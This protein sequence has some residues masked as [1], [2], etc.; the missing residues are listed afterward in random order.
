MSKKYTL[1]K[2]NS[3]KV[4]G[5]TL[6]RVKALRSFSDV[7]KGD[8]G[9][10]IE[11]EDNLSH[12]GSAWVY[13]EARV[14]D[15]PLVSGFASVRGDARVSGKV[16]VYYT[17]PTLRTSSYYVTILKEHIQIECETIP[18]KDFKALKWKKSTILQ[19]DGEKA[20]DFYKDYYKT[21]LRIYKAEFVR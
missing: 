15:K 3:I 7:K 6:Y 21:I 10:Y 5:K 2:G 14:H 4:D 11:T 13:D 1:L 17:V 18:I 20:L 16:H 8:I 9:G 12:E 19:Y